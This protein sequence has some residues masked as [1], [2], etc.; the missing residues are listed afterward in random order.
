MGRLKT[1]D[2]VAAGR[3]NANAASQTRD[4]APSVSV[5][6]RH[7]TPDTS[8]RDTGAALWPI[9]KRLPAYVRLAWGLARE[10]EIPLRHK[11]LLYGAVLYG[12][13]PIH[14][15]LSLIPVV[16][17]VDGPL[18]LLLGIRN[19]LLHCPADAAARRFTQVGLAR[20]QVARDLAEVLEIS[21]RWVR[22]GA[23]GIGRSVALAERA[24]AGCCA[25]A[26]SSQSSLTP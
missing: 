4:D 13:T 5:A 8:V 1:A 24:M 19:A 17:Q 18:L 21:H 26:E 6:T 23:R 25:K 15:P 9:L 14:A 16:G 12:A 11:A 2:E 3:V 7:R 22:K 20:D 10:K